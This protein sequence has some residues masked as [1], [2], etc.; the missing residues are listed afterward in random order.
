[1]RRNPSGLP[2]PQNAATDLPASWSS[3]ESVALAVDQV[4]WGV[5]GFDPAQ[6]PGL[7]LGLRPDRRASAAVDQ[8][9]PRQDDHV[10]AAERTDR[11]AQQA[12]RKKMPQT[13]RLEGIEQ[14]HVDV[15]CQP[16]MLKTVVEHDQLALE[17]VGGD[18]GQGHA[19]GILQMGH[20]GQVFLEDHGPRRSSRRFVHSRGSVSRRARPAARYQRASHSTIGVLPVPPSVRLPTE[21]TGTAARWI[22]FQ[23]RSKPALRTATPA[24]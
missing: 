2:I 18:A 7:P 21:T 1:M 6:R 14:H 16:A 23:P 4:E 24:P 17:L 11:F 15:A 13:K 9:G 12:T 22:C 10:G 20:V 8:I 5:P 3:G 19:I